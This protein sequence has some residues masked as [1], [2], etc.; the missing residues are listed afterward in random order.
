[1][2]SARISDAVF[3]HH[4]R[5]GPL[6]MLAHPS[7]KVYYFSF[8]MTVCF[9]ASVTAD[10]LP[11]IT[12]SDT[13]W[14]QW[15]GAKLDGHA[16]SQQTPPTSWSQGANIL[17][18]T[19]VPGRGHGSPTIVSNA[20]YLPTADTER[21]LQSVICFDRAT[22]KQQ[23]ETVVHRG[24]LMHKNEKASQASS[25]ICCDGQ[26]LFIN[27]LNN[28]AVYTT[29]LDLNGKK[30]W[31]QKISDYVLHQGY[32]S[33]PIVYKDLLLVAADNK[34]GGAI[35]GLDRQSGEE[36]WRH[37][38]PATPNYP[39]PIVIKAYGKDQLIMIGCDLVTSLDPSTGKLNWEIEG[40]TTECVTS[41]VTNGELIYTSGGYPKNHLAAV[42]ADGS[43][44][45]VWETGDRV[46]V[47]SLLMKDGYLYG[48]MD[49][50]V[51]A[52]WDAATG[53][54]QW[55]ARLGGN[56]T[57]SP[58]LVGDLIFA[59]NEE[60]TTTVYRAS[61]S[62]FQK[63]AENKL[64]DDSFATP[65]IVGDRIYARMGVREGDKRQEYLFCVGQ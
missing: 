10:E 35:V 62:E 12:L 51:A 36:I 38:R 65:T 44:E 52:C 64:G 28:G 43:G 21:D 26:R 42:R 20:V 16:A 32:G 60:G 33:S 7:S 57:S 55:K 46:Y 41:T 9:V 30:L 50:G 5:L 37:G 1:M 17:W 8:L 34:G 48:V 2:S 6:R 54:L 23:W 13:D 27:F 31:Q 15:R 53:D 45:V 59:A 61:P 40:A 22:G 63:L 47:P 29:A 56:Y 3:L 49:A 11:K 24:G 14:P 25:T 58:V 4:P 18:S 39:S 19:P